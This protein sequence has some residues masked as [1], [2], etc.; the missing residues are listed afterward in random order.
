MPLVSDTLEGC[1]LSLQT[2]SAHLFAN[3]MKN[4][5]ASHPTHFEALPNCT[6]VCCKSLMNQR[7]YRL[8]ILCA[9]GRARLACV[10][11]FHWGNQCRKRFRSVPLWV[12]RYLRTKIFSWICSRRFYG[13]FMSR[14]EVKNI[15][16]GEYTV[17][18]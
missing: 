6:H 15:E 18:Q 1:C 13:L 9:G 3:L 2:P 12:Q 17:S 7:L 5:G 16:R 10:R 14:F 4:S 11:A 8:F